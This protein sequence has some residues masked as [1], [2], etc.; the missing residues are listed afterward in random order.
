MP[1]DAELAALA[2]QA[3]LRERQRAG[4]DATEAAL[5]ALARAA[6]RTADLFAARTRGP[7][8]A[9]SPGAAQS[10]SPPDN[11]GIPEVTTVIAPVRFALQSAIDR[12]LRCDRCASAVTLQRRWPFCSYLA[13]GRQDE[14]AL[15]S[16][17]M[18][19]GTWAD[20]L[21][22]RSPTKPPGARDRVG[23]S[24]SAGPSRKDA[25][26]DNGAVSSVVTS[27]APVRCHLACLTVKEPQVDWPHWCHLPCFG[28]TAVVMLLDQR[29]AAGR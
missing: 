6:P 21:A 8:R 4:L 10:R 20:S 3:E 13:T 14:I 15:L 5:D 17:S 28:T 12:T 9:S 11:R 29:A 2:E 7:P 19:A 24:S 25:D 26:A 18:G 23:F 16:Q 1:K 27:S 22:Q